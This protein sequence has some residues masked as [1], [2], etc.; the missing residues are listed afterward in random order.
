M[1]I[2]NQAETQDLLNRAKLLNSA[3]ESGYMTLATTLSQ[4]NSTEAFKALGYDTFFDYAKE[5]L[6]RTKGT[7]SKLLKVGDW[8]VQQQYE[9][10]K[11]ETSYAR[12]YESLNL[13]KDKDPQFILAAAQTNS[14]SELEDAK[15]E[16]KH[17]VHEHTPSSEDRFAYC[18][19]GKLIKI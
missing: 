2:M 4:I 15:R 18:H 3:V 10:E 6:N 1:E 19:C 14:Q 8:I 5:E 11:L 17:G 7:V 9:P 16:A 13:N 12:L